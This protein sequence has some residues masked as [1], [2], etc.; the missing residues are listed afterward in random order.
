MPTFLKGHYEE[1]KLNNKEQA[2]KL[3]SLYKGEYLADFEGLWAVGKRIK[4]HE[5]Y[6]EAKKYFYVVLPKNTPCGVFLCLD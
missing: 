3:L 2:K 4:Y 6:E 5:I 1:F